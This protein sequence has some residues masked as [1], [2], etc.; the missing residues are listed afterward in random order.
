MPIKVNIYLRYSEQAFLL[1]MS[2]RLG[3]LL[4]INDDLIKLQDDLN[5]SFLTRRK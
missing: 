5:Q 2:S 3:C 1:E 4:V